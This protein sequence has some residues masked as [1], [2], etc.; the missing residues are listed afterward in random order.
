MPPP[1]STNEVKSVIST[2]LLAIS[3][4]F[5]AFIVLFCANLQILA[6]ILNTA[7]ANFVFFVQGL[8]GCS[9]PFLG[10][11]ILLMRLVLRILTIFAMCITVIHTDK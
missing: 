1:S 8:F 4:P 5:K 7:R 9:L 11:L 10:Y 2:L 6:D 3:V